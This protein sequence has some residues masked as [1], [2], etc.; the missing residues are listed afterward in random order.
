MNFIF[1]IGTKVIFGEGVIN[2]LNTIIRDLNGEK[3]FF[4]YDK[5]VLNAGIMEPLFNILKNNNIEYVEFSEVEPNPSIDTIEKA[6]EIG[7]NEKV[8]II[9]A[10][11]GGS[12][13]DTAKAVNVLLTNPSPLTQYEGFGITVNQT[14]PLITI[15]TTSGTASEVTS[16]SVITNKKETRKFIIAG[17]QLEPTIALVDPELTYK[18]PPSITAST[19]MDALTHAVESYLSLA[20]TSL[21]RALSIKSI[22]LIYKNIRIAYKDGLNKEARA[23]MILGS[24]MAGLAFNNT[25][26]GIVHAFAHP[27]SAHCNLA[28]GVANAIALPYG[29][30]YNS[31]VV[32]NLVKEVGTAMGLKLSECS[33]EEAS[34]LVI[35]ELKKLSNELGIPKLSDIGVT[36]EM[37][38]TLAEAT[39]EEK[40]SLVTNPRELNFDDALSLLKKMF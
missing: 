39:L 22:E 10:V 2:S 34:Q 29:I 17:K 23:N 12:P 16:V 6:A 5:G 13:M 4:I 33:N 15:P 40:G 30:E 37:I 8:D 14:K 38:E 9:V 26:L 1:G 3:V 25:G 36:K 20:G 32:P 24:L 21:T 35:E 19:G 28:H 7:R 11:G 31:K 18:L 27:F